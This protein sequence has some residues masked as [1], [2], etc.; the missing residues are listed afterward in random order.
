MYWT[1]GHAIAGAWK[2]PITASQALGRG[3]ERMPLG[4]EEA[5]GCPIPFRRLVPATAGL[6]HLVP[7]AHFLGDHAAELV[8]GRVL[9]LHPL[10]AKRLRKRGHRHDGLGGCGQLLHDRRRRAL[11]RDQAEQVVGTEVLPNAGLPPEAPRRQ[12]QANRSPW[13]IWG[14]RRTSQSKEIL[15]RRIHTRRPC[16][17]HMQILNR[18]LNISFQ[19]KHPV[20]ERPDNYI[21]LVQNI[22]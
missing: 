14:A 4:R 7:R 15:D 5:P 16:H 22:V 18:V 2:A 9:D 13:L 20:E 19:A 8:G 17:H 3:R 6:R 12:L 1:H 10:R 11:G 21:V